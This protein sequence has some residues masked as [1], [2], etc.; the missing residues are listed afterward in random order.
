MFA[1]P[2]EDEL[3]RRFG[4]SAFLDMSIRDFINQVLTIDCESSRNGAAWSG[5]VSGRDLISDYVEYGKACESRAYV[6][7]MILRCFSSFEWLTGLDLKVVL[8]S[9]GDGYYYY[10]ID[11]A[12]YGDAPEGGRDSLLKFISSKNAD[13]CVAALKASALRIKRGHI[14]SLLDGFNRGESVSGLFVWEEVVDVGI[15]FD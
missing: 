7:D 5:L 13:R 1:I 3:H 15:P 12:I 8:D 6:G 9:D 11:A 10:E 4:D 2:S 14:Q